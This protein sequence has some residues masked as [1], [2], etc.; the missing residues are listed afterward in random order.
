[1]EAFPSPGRQHPLQRRLT[2]MYSETKRSYDT[3]TE[4]PK[5]EITPEMSSLHRKLRI[6]KDRLITWGLEW[7]DTTAAQPGDIDESLEREGFA[8]V[9]SNV[10]SSIKEILEEAERMRFSDRPTAAEPDSY[11]VGAKYG[12][13]PPKERWSAADKPRF[14]ELL[15]DLTTSI[16]TLFNLSKSRRRTTH[17]PNPKRSP[18]PAT[19]APSAAGSGKGPAAAAVSASPPLPRG[20]L[21]G[22]IDVSSL[23]LPEEAGRDTLPPYETIATPS[24]SRSMGYIRR[25]QPVAQPW[26]KDGPSVATVPVLIE[27]APFDP[28]Y[29][30]TGISPSTARLENLAEALQDSDESPMLPGTRVL[31]LIGY[32]ECPKQPRFGLVYELP[33]AVFSGPSDPE[34]P[35]ASM[36]PFTLLSL[37]QA[38]PPGQNA[39]V[40]N[41]EDRLRLAFSLATTF[42]HLHTKD[43]TH[44]DVTSNN[45]VFFR[46]PLTTR[47]SSGQDFGCDLR[48]P[49][50]TSFDLFSDCDLEERPEQRTA[51]IYRHPR[52]LRTN[53]A[54]PQHDYSLAF[55]IYGLGMILLEIGLWMPLNSFWKRSYNIATFQNR[56]EKIYV[57]KLG[58]KCGGSYMRAVESCLSAPAREMALAGTGQKANTQWHFF[59][60]VIK[61][62]ERCCA[63]DDAASVPFSDSL[64]IPTLSTSSSV[65]EE[66]MLKSTLGSQSQ[67]DAPLPEPMAVEGADQ[68]AATPNVAPAPASARLKVHPVQVDRVQ[69]NEWHKHLLPRLERLLEKVLHG[70][71]ETFT[72]DLIGI[73]DTAQTAR[74]TILITCSSVGKVKGIL[75]RHFAY[76]QAVFDL[77]VRKGKLRRSHAG[78]SRARQDGAAPRSAMH[79]GDE[80]DPEVMNPFHQER[81]LCGASIGAFKETTERHH[82]AVSYGG[83]VLVDDEPYGMTV[84]HL[85]DDPSSDEDEESDDEVSPARSSGILSS[86]RRR[87]PRWAPP[88]PPPAP[89]PPGAFEGTYLSDVSDEDTEDEGDANAERQLVWSALHASP[90]DAEDEYR[91]I[92]TGDAAGIQVGQQTDYII[93]QPALD[94]VEQDFFPN[95]EDKNE[96]HLESHGFGTIYASSGIRRLVQGNEKHEIDWALVK[97]KPDRLQPFNVVQGGRRY[98][99][100]PD[101][102][103]RPALISPIPRH[104]N[105]GE[106]DDLYPRRVASLDELP[107]LA[108]HCLGRTS[109]LQGGII[110]PAMSSVRVAGRAT[111]SRSWHVFGKLGV[112]GD[113]GAWIIDNQQGRVCGHVL[114]WCSRNKWAYICPMQILLEDMERTLPARRVT[115]PGGEAHALSALPSRSSARRSDVAMAGLA[116]IN[117]LRLASPSPETAE[118][119]SSAAET[120]FLRK[121]DPGVGGSRQVAREGR[122]VSTQTAKG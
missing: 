118:R 115:L 70:P 72:I 34:K 27:Y 85:L 26:Q 87:P 56:I 33:E 102:A 12:K 119:S 107:N 116:D 104:P 103:R 61:P 122:H 29:A 6:Q 110:S 88:P 28:V 73:G 7:S 90:R 117:Q 100:D 106:E 47:S 13:T 108:V 105:H 19:P 71:T 91:P 78:K 75:K 86:N 79:S 65:G 111:T 37:L 9:V 3:V 93:T 76:D 48:S 89:T 5:V 54:T 60:T 98:C 64:A 44:R 92:E 112:P 4:P 58:Q 97:I 24:N 114:A 15:H 94:D 20:G 109:G 81:P 17:S 120:P 51:H 42:L 2:K 101:V 50:L 38:N 80:D 31:H 49:Y 10:M 43:V 62:L 82:A 39:S 55:D 36:A 41:L 84:H 69:L 40:P 63:I 46:T 67:P 14:Q 121:D 66:S 30:S 52:D 16:D 57:K 35:L 22:R 23:I 11:G 53:Q 21:A 83:V 8:S 77:R 1:M 96:E 59:C 68:S 113:S 74:P 32:F 95:E 99:H 25:P 18:A 45:I